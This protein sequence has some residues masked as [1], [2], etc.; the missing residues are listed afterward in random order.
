M[1]DS[2]IQLVGEHDTLPVIEQG[3]N[4]HKV[5]FKINN[6]KEVIINYIKEGEEFSIY[7]KAQK[8]NTSNIEFR[9]AENN[10]VI[11]SVE[12]IKIK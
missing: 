2:I 7:L 1:K 5:L 6:G 11:I 10:Y 8:D 3:N 12:P 9:D 4:T